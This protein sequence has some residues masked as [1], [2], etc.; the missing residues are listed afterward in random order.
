MFTPIYP[1]SSLLI[2]KG[3]LYKS[4]KNL[5]I[6]GYREL[7]ICKVTC[8]QAGEHNEK[9]KAERHKRQP[10]TTLRVLGVCKAL[11]DVR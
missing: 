2:S 6:E 5:W 7:G 8:W 3:K 10:L 4:S 11:I 1:S 9:L